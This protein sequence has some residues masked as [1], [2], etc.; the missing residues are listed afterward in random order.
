MYINIKLVKTN[1]QHYL[2]L[3]ISKKIYGNLLWLLSISYV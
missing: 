1:R 2:I 3:D